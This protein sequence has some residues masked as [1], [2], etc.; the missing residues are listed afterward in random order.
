MTG[1]LGAA[2]ATLFAIGLGV[3]LIIRSR[4]ARALELAL[5]RTTEN[6][7]HIE[8]AFSRFAPQGVV[9][10]FTSGER[11]IPPTRREVTVL[12]ADIV[13][14]TQL[15]ESVDPTVLV[16]ILNDY[17]RRMTRVIRERHG[18]VSRIMGDGLMALFGSLD[19]NRWQAADAVQA[20]LAMRSA[21]EELNA[22]LREKSQLELR[23]GVGIHQGDCVAA[24]IGSHDM[25]EFTVLGDPVNI[26]ARVEALTRTHQVDI[27]VTAQIRDKLDERFRLREMPATLVKGKAEPVTT[28]A[29]EDFD[30]AR[31]TRRDDV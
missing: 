1:W 12:F 24:V 26:A 19:T 13:G 22:E 29:V 21:L 5:S 15:S 11:E 20:A 17:F 7:E 3:L 6:L 2:V 9:E 14:F 16:P 8:Q 28:W 23:I 10:M 27:L 30:A 18:H 4:R 25:M 31:S